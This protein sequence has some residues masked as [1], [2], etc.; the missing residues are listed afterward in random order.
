MRTDKQLFKIFEAVPDW[1]FQLAGL[2][3]PGKSTLQ[4]CTVKALERVAD[5][6]VVPEA[7]DQPLTIVEF[8]FQKRRHHLHADSGRDGRCPTAP[9]RTGRAGGDLLRV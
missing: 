8:Q 6:V 1:L 3:S 9:S 2:P 5:G 7:S 4:S